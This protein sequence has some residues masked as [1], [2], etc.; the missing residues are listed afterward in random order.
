MATPKIFIHVQVCVFIFGGIYLMDFQYTPD[1]RNKACFKQRFYIVCAY[2]IHIWFGINW[3]TCSD[4]E[5]ICGIFVQMSGRWSNWWNIY[6]NVRPFHVMII[7]MSEYSLMGKYSLVGY[8]TL[9]LYN[10]IDR[11]HVETVNLSCLSLFLLL[12][13]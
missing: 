3:K 9:I 5:D 7:Q 6:T 10:I 2:F 8:C 4:V 13:I 11:S 1:A 12:Y